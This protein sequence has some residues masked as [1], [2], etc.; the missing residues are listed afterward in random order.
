MIILSIVFS[1]PSPVFNPLQNLIVPAPEGDSRV[2]PDHSYLLFYFFFNIFEEGSSGW[3]NAVT[4]HEIL[5]DHDPSSAGH[6]IEL[7]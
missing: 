5:E 1:T 7:W 2:I 4:K 6:L 3:V